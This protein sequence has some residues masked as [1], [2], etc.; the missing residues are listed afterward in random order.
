ME[1]EPLSRHRVSP[2]D[3]PD[4]STNQ[5]IQ[6]NDFHPFNGK[7]LMDLSK[8]TFLTFKNMKSTYFFSASATAGSVTQGDNED[9]L[10]WKKK[11]PVVF[12]PL[13]KLTFDFQLAADGCFT[14][15]VDGFAGVHATVKVTGPADLQ[16]TD[17]LNADL[18][19]FGVVSNN[20][21][22]LHPLN[23]GLWWEGK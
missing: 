21:L 1:S 5:H 18:P 15:I 20:H 12:C 7:W 10:I 2:Q 9:F 19:E 16:R 14:V 17:T 6:V 13:N 4:S 3:S 8:N 22:V 11:S 23:L